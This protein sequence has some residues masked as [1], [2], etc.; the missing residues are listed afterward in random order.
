MGTKI[1]YYL[2]QVGVK[3]RFCLGCE[4]PI[5]T[6]GA[7]DWCSHCLANKAVSKLFIKPRRKALAN[8]LQEIRSK[9]L[10]AKT[11]CE[12]C[13][14]KTETLLY[15]ENPKLPLDFQWLC[16]SCYQKER[17][18]KAWLTLFSRNEYQLKQIIQRS[19]VQPITSWTFFYKQ[20]ARSTALLMARPMAK[21]FQKETAPF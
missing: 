19:Q 7:Q 16:V 1:K 4:K 3:D 17:T 18:D 9:D 6:K 14:S 8:A 10:K 11:T 2:A 20:Q 12:H 15:Q 13:Q 5:R 21:Q